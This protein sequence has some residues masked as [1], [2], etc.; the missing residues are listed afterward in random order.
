M[1]SEAK[2][3]VVNEDAGKKKQKRSKTDQGASSEPAQPSAQQAEEPEAKG[4][5]EAAGEGGE[6]DLEM[7]VVAEAA[8]GSELFADLAI[9]DQLKGE[10]SMWCCCERFWAEPRQNRS[11][12]SL[13]LKK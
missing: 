8:A 2:Q 13:A 12:L 3:E 11:K 7:D 9:C 6:K 5:V 4:E 10:T 1:E